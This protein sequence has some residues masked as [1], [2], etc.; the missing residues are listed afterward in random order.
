MLKSCRRIVVCPD[1]P[2]SS[3]AFA[4][5]QDPS[6]TESG[7]SWLGLDRTVSRAPSAALLAEVRRR[8]VRGATH[9]REMQVLVVASSVNA[10]GEPLTGALREARYLAGR[11]RG[12]QVRTDDASLFEGNAA[13]SLRVFGLIHI[14]AHTELNGDHPWRSGVLLRPDVGDASGAVWLRAERVLGLR[15]AARL[16]VLSGCSSAGGGARLGEGAE[17]LSAAFLCAGVPT[18]VA[19]LWPVDDRA[20]ARLVERFY[21]HLARGA[22]VSRALQHAQREMAAADGAIPFH[23]AAFTVVGDPDSRVALREK[24]GE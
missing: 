23:W 5:L 7:V 8:S 19:T 2:L 6:T 17:G 10:A 20:T 22:T 15:L 21:A 1:G 24:P 18:V 11:Y 14:A 4:A 3:V 12:V 13:D 9:G 16:A